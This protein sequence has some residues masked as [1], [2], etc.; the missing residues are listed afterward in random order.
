MWST[1][2]I[3]GPALD[4]DVRFLLGPRVGIVHPRVVDMFAP[5]AMRN[6]SE[7][8]SLNC[9]EDIYPSPFSKDNAHFSI[10]NLVSLILLM[11]TQCQNQWH[12]RFLKSNLHLLHTLYMIRDPFRLSLKYSES[13]PE[14]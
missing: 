2:G 1:K 5:T 4:P 14:Q 7:R 13:N 9:S 12:V 8:C 11:D 3:H 10:L 6:G